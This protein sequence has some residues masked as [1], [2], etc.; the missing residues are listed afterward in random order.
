[1]NFQAYLENAYRIIK[2]E[3]FILIIGGF[4]VHLLTVFSLGLLAGPFMGGYTLLIIL[5]LRENK[6]P[7]F[8]DI[9][10][11]LQQ[12]ANLFPYFLI[13]LFIFI[14][15][16]LLILPGLIFAT[17][18]IYVLPLMVDRQ[19]PFMKAMQL[20]MTKVNEKGFLM[21][22]VFLLLLYFIP[23]LLINLFSAII[24]LVFILNILLPPFQI[25]CLSSLYIDQFGRADDSIGT[26]EDYEPETAEGS[27]PET[28]IN[29]EEDKSIVERSNQDQRDAQPEHT[30]D[31]EHDDLKNSSGTD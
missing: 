12:F 9:F 3:P 7:V 4:V 22:F 8:N 17:W 20:S 18:W 6:R 1:M 16:K 10:S 29:T 27:G 13:L 25:S 14:G 31:T 5:Y 2:E 11:G 19:M 15:L 24:P 30:E 21:H 26:T 28:G 23:I